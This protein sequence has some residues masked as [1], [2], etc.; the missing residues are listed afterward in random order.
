MPA[1]AKKVIY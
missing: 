1:N